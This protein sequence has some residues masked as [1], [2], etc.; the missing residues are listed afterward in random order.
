MK[1]SKIG[2]VLVVLGLVLA[3]IAPVWKWAIAPSF[4]KLPDDLDRV[5]KYEGTITLYA[6]PESMTLIPP[7]QA[8]EIPLDITRTLKSVGT[9]GNIVKIEEKAEGVGPDGKVYMEYTRI[10]ALDR[11]TAENVAGHGSDIDREGQTLFYPFGVEKITYDAWE[12]DTGELIE[13]KYVGEETDGGTD[14]KEVETYVFEVAAEGELLVPPMG[15]PEELTGS[16]IKAIIGN[17]NLAL[18]DDDMVP[19]SYIKGLGVTFA[20]EPRTGAPADIMD[21]V[22]EYY[23]DTSALGMEPLKLAEVQYAQTEESVKETV[24]SITDSISKLDL[25]EKWLPLIFLLVGIVLVVL[26]LAVGLRKKA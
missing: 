14:G 20:I 5:Q 23:V 26:G 6:D 4:V 15:L 19:I 3:I 24:D 12:S 10:H 21:Y 13:A 16:A 8:A 9:E 25:V 7:E 2:I 1:L 11:K 22:I 18:A 17:P